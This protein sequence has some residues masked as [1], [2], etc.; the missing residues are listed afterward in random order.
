MARRTKMNF[1]RY[2][3]I[4]LANNGV[5]GDN[6]YVENEV[7]IMNGDNLDLSSGLSVRN[8]RSFHL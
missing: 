6:S 3:K 1:G 2:L 7:Q 4:E 8:A 5:F